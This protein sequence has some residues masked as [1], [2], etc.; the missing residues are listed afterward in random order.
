MDA[1]AKLSVGDRAVQASGVL[2]LVFVTPLTLQASPSLSLRV[3][4]F[5]SLHSMLSTFLFVCQTL[6]IQ[7]YCLYCTVL[8][9]I[10]RRGDNGPSDV[11]FSH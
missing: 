10:C 9:V 4:S 6:R 8:S 5:H 11:S 3:T 1:D 7:L 2:G